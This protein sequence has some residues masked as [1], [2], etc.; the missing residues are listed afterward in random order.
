VIGFGKEFEFEV[1]SIEER[2]RVKFHFNQS[3]G[4]LRI[5]VDG[6]PALRK[7]ILFSVSLDR[8]FEFTVGQ[9]ERH[10]VMIEM[11]RKRVLGGLLPQSYAVFIDG[12]EK[13]RF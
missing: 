6:K 13:A 8:H 5:L 7:F 3:F 4:G 1:G 10:Q 9:E 11:T 2:H 12:T